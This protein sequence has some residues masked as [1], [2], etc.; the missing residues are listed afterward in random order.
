MEKTKTYSAVDLSLVENGDPNPNCNTHHSNSNCHN[1]QTNFNYL[2]HH[3]TKSKKLNKMSID[4]FSLLCSDRDQLLWRMDTKLE[5]VAFWWILKKMET[6]KRASVGSRRM[7]SWGEK[8]KVQLTFSF[9]LQFSAMK[10]SKNGGIVAEKI[11]S[12]WCFSGG[13]WIVWG[14]LQSSPWKSQEMVG[15]FFTSKFPAPLI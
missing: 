9:Y 4:F 7:E 1:L 11:E 13:M 2:T 15:R 3:W 5:S 6:E 8:L 10:F 14:C 12:V